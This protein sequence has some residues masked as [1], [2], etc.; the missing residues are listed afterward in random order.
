MF[1][2]CE[3]PHYHRYHRFGG[4]GIKVCKRWHSSNL[5]GFENFVHDMPPH[6]GKGYSLDRIDNDGDY[7]P[8]NCQWATAQEQALNRLQSPVG[9]S[10]LRG[11]RSTP[12]GRYSS[13][14]RRLGKHYHLGTFGT[15]M[16]AAVAREKFCACH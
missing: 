5:V 1:D 13:Y 6:P 3:N 10:G 9:R 12:R 14:V 15:A 4:R 2:R 7:T 8:E 16:E 11:V